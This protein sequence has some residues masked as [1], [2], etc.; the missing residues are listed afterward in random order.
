VAQM[1]GTTSSAKTEEGKKMEPQFFLNLT[2]TIAGVF[3][4]IIING[5]SAS[6]KKLREVDDSLMTKVQAI[7]L[8]VAGSYVKRDDLDRLTEAL[9]RKLDTIEGKLDHKQDKP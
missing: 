3:G 9:F 2:L 6:M 8:L 1:P 4:G 5:L 7:E